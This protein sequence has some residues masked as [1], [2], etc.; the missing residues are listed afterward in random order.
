MS[1]F[2]R[3]RCLLFVSWSV[4]R[5]FFS[6]SHFRFL[7]VFG[8]LMLLLSVLFLVTV[9]SLPPQSSSTVFLLSLPPRFLYCL[10]ILVSMSFFASI[11]H[12]F[13]WVVFFPRCLSDSKYFQV[14]SRILLRLLADLNNAER[15]QFF[16]WSPISPISLSTPW[17]LFQRYCHPHVPQ[18]FFLSLKQ[19]PGIYGS[20]R[21]LLF[22]LLGSLEKSTR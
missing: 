22:S 9:I 2:S 20:F 17:R 19:D 12:Q 5:V 7:V 3:V 6:S 11:S 16:L 18:F 15:F 8:L 13:K 10:R 4:H 1:K 21:F 14:S